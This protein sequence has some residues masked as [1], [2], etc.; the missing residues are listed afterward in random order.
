ML[1]FIYIIDIQNG[2]LFP[3]GLTILSHQGA[4]LVTSVSLADQHAQL[5]TY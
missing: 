3:T 1:S 5:W 4:L 2:V